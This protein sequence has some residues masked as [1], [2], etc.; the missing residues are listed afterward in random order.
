MKK[1]LYGL[2]FFVV[3]YIL[4]IVCSFDAYKLYE[5]K[6]GVICPDGWSWYGDVATRIECKDEKCILELISLKDGLTLKEF[7][8]DDNQTENLK[9]IK[10]R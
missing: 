9:K 4:F 5:L 8:L 3:S 2:S 7:P 1:S 10:C 6:D